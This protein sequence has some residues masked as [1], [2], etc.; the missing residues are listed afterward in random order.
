MNTMDNAKVIEALEKY[1]LCNYFE[2][3]ISAKMFK[4]VLFSIFPH[5]AAANLS[6]PHEFVL[7]EDIGR[8]AS[9]NRGRFYN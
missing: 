7:I 6:D 9:L 1:A 2:K 5:T 8:F 4:I 3:L